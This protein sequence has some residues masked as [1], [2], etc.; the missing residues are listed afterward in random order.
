MAIQVFPDQQGSGWDTA[1]AA[2]TQ[3]FRAAQALGIEKK[4][5]DLEQQRV[6]SQTNLEGSQAAENRA[7]IK[8]LESRAQDLAWQQEAHR[9]ASGHAFNLDD[10]QALA[11][12]LKGRDPN[13]ASYV[14]QFVDAMRQRRTDNQYKQAL[15]GEAA[16]QAEATTRRTNREK[17]V[18]EV[19]SQYRGRLTNPRDIVQAASDAAVIDPAAGASIMQ[20]FMPKGQQ[21]VEGANDKYLVDTQNN[22]V[23][24]LHIGTRPAGVGGAGSVSQQGT[25]FAARQALSEL[26]A[27]I[28]IAGRDRSA[29]VVPAAAAAAEGITGAH[30]P[31]I[32]RVFSG[33]GGLVKQHAMTANQ[34][35]FQRH[36]TSFLHLYGAIL[37]RSRNT[38][39][40]MDNF[41]QSFSMQ[42]GQESGANLADLLKTWQRLRAQIRPMAGGQE[43]DMSTLPLFNE[44]AQ[45]AAAEAVPNSGP[46]GEA[47]GLNYG[48]YRDSVPQ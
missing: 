47:P 25:Q 14:L 48:S 37:P 8:D 1:L 16:A 32:G 13:V 7:K 12:D 15:I 35:L 39:A 27:I 20:T 29:P 3:S 42:A 46:A 10:P 45:A 21:V 31:G 41:K 26:D 23:R 33:V 9:V 44:A 4:K 2:F 6:T 11:A 18:S 30:A 40:L 36:L 5:L 28:S 38:M 17:G 24:P 22:T 19:L 43:T 34:Q